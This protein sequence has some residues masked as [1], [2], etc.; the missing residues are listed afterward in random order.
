MF[1]KIFQYDPQANPILTIL[2]N[3][4]ASQAAMEVETKWLE[5]APVPSWLTANA[6]IN[7]TATTLVLTS[8]QGAYVLPNAHILKNMTTGELIQVTA[9]AGDSLTIVRGYAGTTAGSIATTDNLLNLR[10]AFGQGTLSPVS[11]STTKATKSN[12]CQIRKTT[13]T[14]TKTLD[15]VALYG[16]DE[17]VYQ[18]NKASNEHA[19]DWEH[20]LLHGVKGSV[21]SSQANPVYMTGGLDYYITTNV[22]ATSGTLTHSEFLDFL[23]NVFRYSVSGSPGKNKMLFASAEVINTINS[24]GIAKLQTTPAS[25]RA[26]QTYGIDIREYVSGFGRLNVAYHPLLEQGAKGRAYIID[27]DGVMMRPLRPTHM[28]TNVQAPDADV[29]KDEILTEAGFMVAEELT[30]GVITGVAY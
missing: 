8:G 5:D 1:P 9:V 2:T 3:R 10:G 22:L 29:Y 16:G 20:I 24:W 21:V 4:V 11:L 23:P 19:R 18:R 26:S 6:G 28:N 30:H 27:L 7:N 25:D 13:V 12:Y 15:A 17:R 14:V